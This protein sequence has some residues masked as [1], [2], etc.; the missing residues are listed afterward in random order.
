[1]PIKEFKQDTQNMDSFARDDNQHGYDFL[2]YEEKE[3]YLY[4]SQ[5]VVDETD[6][7]YKNNALI[8]RRVQ[9][10][11]LNNTIKKDKNGKPYILAKFIKSQDVEQINKLGQKG[12]EEADRII[13]SMRLLTRQY[14]DLDKTEKILWLSESDTIDSNAT[15]YRIFS[16]IIERAPISFEPEA[17]EDDVSDNDSQVIIEATNTRFFNRNL[18]NYFEHFTSQSNPINKNDLAISLER[19]TLIGVNGIQILGLKNENGKIIENFPIDV[20][21]NGSFFPW[22]VSI[23]DIKDEKII[24]HMDWYDNNVILNY[25][26]A[27]KFSK[28][29]GERFQDIQITKPDNTKFIFQPDDIKIV[30]D[31]ILITYGFL[32]NFKFADRYTATSPEVANNP[33]LLGKI[34]ESYV[35]G[36]GDYKIIDIQ[37]KNPSKYIQSIFDDYV[38]N[39]PEVEYSQSRFAFLKSIIIALN[40][41]ISTENFSFGRT[42]SRFNEVYLPYFLTLADGNK[43]EVIKKSDTI[44][45]DNSK[46]ERHILNTEIRFVL[47]SMYLTQNFN[48]VNN[49][50]PFVGITNSS[51]NIIFSNKKMMHSDR[52]VSVVALDNILE[53]KDK[54]SNLGDVITTTNDDLNYILYTPIIYPGSIND[55][56][57]NKRL[58]QPRKVTLDLTSYGLENPTPPGKNF[59]E[60]N[61]YDS[62]GDFVLKQFK[63]I[64]CHANNKG[65]CDWEIT[66][67]PVRTKTKIANTQIKDS[68]VTKNITGNRKDFDYSSAFVKSVNVSNFRIVESKPFTFGGPTVWRKT[69]KYKVDVNIVFKSKK[70][71]TK[72]LGYYVDGDTWYD[73]ALL[74]SGDFS[75]A[76]HN[77]FPFEKVDNFTLEIEET[78]LLNSIGGRIPKYEE[79]RRFSTDRSKNNWY[80]DNYFSLDDFENGLYKKYWNIQN[81]GPGILSNAVFSLKDNVQGSIYEAVA[82]MELSRES[83]SNPEI[84]TYSND[85]FAVNFE[86]SSLFDFEDWNK[87]LS[88]DTTIKPYSLI[89]YPLKL[90][91]ADDIIEINYLNIKQIF[92]RKMILHSN[93]NEYTIDLTNQL[94]TTTS[95]EIMVV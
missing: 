35:C 20:K 44:G 76:G 26:I 59:W 11:F 58:E 12:S 56:S 82:N 70:E 45:L 36:Y 49:I 78:W 43:I 13:A 21:V 40:N 75:W 52:S 67:A 62:W 68:D 61:G 90:L 28:P 81:V 38:L 60:Y 23:N 95:F 19:R 84:N 32:T 25:S 31:L 93:D 51:N 54:Y 91:D 87:L 46:E 17:Q 72:A 14:V 55:I 6:F 41:Y 88:Y 2:N 37:N 4:E 50:F 15:F 94:D 30:S 39:R 79:V 8:I 74:V 71:T 27:V 83:Y 92:G 9:P 10:S 24:Y 64:R 77:Q 86:Q 7:Y 69:K 73:I 29:I 5:K 48:N 3:F 16:T 85:K 65:F 66:K 89:K 47:K 80:T 42:K 22:K 34:K 57:K 33:A 18:Q 1:M 53:K 63:G